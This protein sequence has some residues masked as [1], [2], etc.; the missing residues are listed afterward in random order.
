MYPPFPLRVFGQDDFPL[1][2]EGGYPPF[3][4]K[5]FSVKGGRSVHPNCT[6]GKFRYKTGIFGPKTLFLALFGPFYGEIFWR[7]SVK[8]GRRG[9]PNPAELF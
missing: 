4:L 7:F 5:I 8:G 6:K 2:G 3:T 1:R 9:P